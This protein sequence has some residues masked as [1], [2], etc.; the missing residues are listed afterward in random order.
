MTAAEIC[1]HWRRQRFQFPTVCERW[2]GIATATVALPHRAP[3]KY[4]S[5]PITQ[6]P[7]LAIE[8]AAELLGWYAAEGSADARRKQFMISQEIVVNPDHHAQIVELFRRLGIKFRAWERGIGA[9][10]VVLTEWLVE[11]CGTDSRNKRIPTWLKEQHPE[12]LRI[13]LDALIKG[14]GWA[15][16]SSFGYKT[17]SRRLADDVSEIAQ[18]CGFGISMSLRH[19]EWSLGI[20]TI[21]NTPTLNIP[22]VPEHYIGHIHCCAVPNG[23]IYVRSGGKCFWS[24][25]SAYAESYAIQKTIETLDGGEKPAVG[26]YGHWHKMLAGEYRNVW[27]ILVPSTKDQDPFMRKKRIR[28]VV[29]GGIVTLEQDPETGAIFGMTPRLWRYFVKS[30]YAEQNRRWS[31]SGPVSLPAR[32]TR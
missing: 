23:L 21:Q 6:I 22:P 11:Q 14:D 29:G 30:Y 7:D 19:G 5:T 32:D 24:H 15:I 25:N 31:H 20:R 17:I 8:D 13:T 16:G 9:C 1:E 26:L 4:A 18:K 28:S 3:R 12:I 27:F 10:S 2:G